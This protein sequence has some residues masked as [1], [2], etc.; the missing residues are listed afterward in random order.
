MKALLFGYN[1]LN[2]KNGQFLKNFYDGVTVEIIAFRILRGSYTE[3]V[4]F[5]QRIFFQSGKIFFT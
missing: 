4:L 5:F 2:V 1:A 3:I